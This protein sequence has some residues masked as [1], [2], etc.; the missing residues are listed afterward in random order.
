MDAH[1]I[2][3]IDQGASG[4]ARFEVLRAFSTKATN[5]ALALQ[6]RIYEVGAK[7]PYQMAVVEAS[8]VPALIAALSQMARA[9]EAR[10]RG[11]ATQNSTTSHRFGS[12]GI[13][14]SSSGSE[15]RVYLVAG[16]KDPAKLTL[17]LDG[18]GRVETLVKRAAEKIRELE[19]VHEKG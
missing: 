1:P 16:D 2:G 5:Y 8:D 9:A 4:A 13:G 18:L 17:D 11:E 15:D 10:K 6:V 3:V 19:R 14:L 7:P 12:L